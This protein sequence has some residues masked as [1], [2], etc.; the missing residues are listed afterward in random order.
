MNGDNGLVLHVAAACP[1]VT[2]LFSYHLCLRLVT[3]TQSRGCNSCCGDLETPETQKPSGLQP[4]SALSVL[5]CPRHPLA[6]SP[7]APEESQ[8][9]PRV[10]D[11]QAGFSPAC[12]A[13]GIA[14]A[15]PSREGPLCSHSPGAGRA[16]P[17]PSSPFFFLFLPFPFSIDAQNIFSKMH[18]MYWQ[19]RPQTF[20]IQG[21]PP[22]VARPYSARAL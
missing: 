18:K 11:T 8:G 10:Q 6:A 5:G 16:V 1:S 15:Q 22:G 12:P 4:L 9:F 17:L 2:G 13:A 3:V 20:W 14:G 7:C 19:A 21:L